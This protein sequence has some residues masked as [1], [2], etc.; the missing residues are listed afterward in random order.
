MM[1]MLVVGSEPWH[2]PYGEVWKGP[3]KVCEEAVQGEKKAC[4]NP[5]RWPR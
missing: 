2:G 5:P 4:K 1:Y 3:T